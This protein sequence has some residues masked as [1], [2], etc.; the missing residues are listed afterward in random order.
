MVIGDRK[1]YQILK[2]SKVGSLA[3][4]VGVLGRKRL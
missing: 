3:A 1:V 4:L 2:I